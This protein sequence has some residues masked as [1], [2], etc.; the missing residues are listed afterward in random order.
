MTKRNRRLRCILLAGT[1]L[2]ATPLA[3]QELPTGP[4]VA[5]GSVGISTPSAGHMAID[6]SSA[7]AVVN[8]QGF[9][10]GAG[11]RVD[12]RQPSASSALLNR[13]T[14][15]TPSSIAGRI[16]AS[17]QVF[18]VN[19]NGIILTKSGA[20]DA[21]AFVASTLG[22]SDQAFLDGRHEYAGNGRSAAVENHGTIT[23]GPGGYAALIGG[24][25]DNTGSISAPLGRI[26]LG[27]GEMVTLDLAGDGFLQVG[28]PS[29]GD[30]D[31]LIRQSGRLS[32][33]GGRVE[34]KAATAREA[35]RRAINL[36]GVVEARSVSGRSGA[37]VLGGGAGGSVR[38]SGTLSTRAPAPQPEVVSAS[39]HPRPRPAT[40]DV[41]GAEIILTGATLDAS[42]AGGG[43]LV[44]I[45]GDYQGGG[46]LPRAIVTAVDATTSIAADALDAGDGGRVIVWSDALTA[47]EGTITARGGPA[48]GD[49]GFAEVSGRRHLDFGGRVDLLAPH[50]RTGTLL[51]DPVNILITNA[52]TENNELFAQED[53]VD[54]VDFSDAFYA[55]GT[56]S[57]IDV[58][59]LTDQ[60]ATSNVEVHTSDTLLEGSPEDDGDIVVA[61]AISWT[62]ENVLLLNADNDI[63]LAGAVTADNGGLFLSAGGTITTTS[64]ADVTVSDF[65]LLEGSWVQNAAALPGFSA[66]DFQIDGSAFLRAIGGAGT[67]AD[68]YL[69]TDVY[70]LQG[71]DSL[72][73]AG[74]SFLLVQNI[75]AS[76]TAA[77]NDGLGFDP[78]GEPVVLTT[79]FSGTFDGGGH[80]ITGL[81]INRPGSSDPVGLFGLTSSEASISNVGLI[82]ADV[83]GGGDPDSGF[84]STGALVGANGG[85]ITTAFVT[86]SNPDRSGSS[87]TGVEEVGGLAGRN[88]GSISLAY[89]DAAVSGT[90]AVGGLVGDNEGNISQ[91]Y[92]R[93]S[94][95]GGFDVGGLVGEH[96]GSI[97]ESYA[98]GAVSGGSNTGGLIGFDGE[99]TITDSFY[100]QQAT[101]QPP[102]DPGDPAALTTA[103][104][105]DTAGFMALAEPLGWN[106]ETTWAPP[107]PDFYPALYS[108]E[109]VARIAA[110][111]VTAVYGF[112]DGLQ[113]TGTVFGGPAAFAFGPAGDTLGIEAA[114]VLV[115]DGINVGEY[116]IGLDPGATPVTSALGVEYRLVATEGTLSITPAPLTITAG[117]ASKVY[118]DVYPL[119]TTPFA[120]TEGSL[121]PGDSITA[122]QFASEG[123]AATAPVFGSPYEIVASNAE[124]TGLSAG[125]VS[126]YDISFDEGSLTVTPRPLTIT[127][128]SISKLSGTE[129]EFSGDEFSV[130]DGL[131]NGDTVDRV[132]LASDGAP[133]A[134][135]LAGS[136]YAITASNAQGRGLA[137]SEVSNYDFTYVD[138]TL[139]L[140]SPL[141]E[142]FVSVFATLLPGLPN[143]PDD[144]YLTAV[145]GGP[146]SESPSAR[147]GDIAIAESTLSFLESI[148]DNLEEV[149]EA[150]RRSN[151]AVEAYLACLGTALDDYAAQVDRI[152]LDLP[153][154]LR[155]VSAIIQQASR[156]IDAAQE[157][158]VR[159]LATAETDAERAEIG[160]EAAA[161]ARAAIGTATVEIRK[162]IALIRAD[163]PQLANLQVDQGNAITAALDS[164]G[165]N[166]ER[167]VG[168]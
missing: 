82:D 128:N 94:V 137:V 87:V 10:V 106:F 148:A 157:R 93:G 21:G 27:A 5:H 134:A 144:F 138:G 63:S 24:R 163:E 120:I 6:Q 33:D 45:G 100:D 3:A 19:P 17:G 70:G 59:D 161:E 39:P 52:A 72:G 22:I 111:E 32:A 92:A 18:L 133:A 162:A 42:G 54:G 68:P 159:R 130:G 85:I 12:I 98:V 129:V 104:F 7:E 50:G 14:G 34:I 1:A 143:P 64:Q 79:P 9:S 115:T 36:S 29:D 124:G 25:I 41:T 76:G 132:D 47:F 80:T 166:L 35:A 110:D 51:L 90:E 13:V 102:D 147:A 151:P 112:P 2:S 37:I 4:S 135:P 91:S 139:A 60:L 77:W 96:F 165:A 89:S 11:G 136:P 146:I 61:T 62:S 48:G 121:A 140:E 28:I 122:V 74:A 49:G 155:G 107:S 145:E 44:R 23:V 119:A 95:T 73:Y 109:A 114:D 26:G 78:I 101:G 56:P 15:P 31:A 168:L 83:T 55:T 30:D 154:P 16:T 141:P 160:R 149:V 142:A 127:A 113:L 57:V 71:M 131:V 99:G 108:V 123:A 164:V 167:A 81:T 8:W 125:G 126:N 53:V 117:S 150:C 116:A 20:V 105:Q 103:E 84:G 46:D 88:D 153:E 40:I 86:G 156:E 69:L 43:G 118:G 152:S 58:T 66:T 65:R 67:T 75:D 158:A 97:D 38:V